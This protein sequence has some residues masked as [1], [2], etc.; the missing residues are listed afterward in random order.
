MLAESPADRFASYAALAAALEPFAAG[1][2]LAALAR[3]APPPTAPLA[4]PP[5]L[6]AALDLLVWD[7]AGRRH[8]SLAEPG[9]LP[10]REGSPFQIEVR[11]N[12]PAYLY[13]VW[14]DTHGRPL[15]LYPWR[16]GTWDLAEAEA[17]RAQLLLPQPD[18][19]RGYQPWALN[20][21][22]GVETVVLVA[23]EGGP[24]ADLPGLFT[25]GLAARPLRPALEGLPQ[26]ERGYWFTSRAEEHAP[27]TRG[28]NLSPDFHDPIF[29]I[30]SF[31]REQLG[32]R[33]PLLRAVS[34]ANLGRE[35]GPS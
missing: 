13:L 18:P 33:V 22:A 16:P 7:R 28:L 26:R 27:G 3:S 24:R 29:Q 17:P 5:P 32:A 35:G 34:F 10:L 8:R 25:A 1:S 15:P 14:L 21:E 6:H 30:H 11:L 23:Q 9:V 2:E 19:M 4:A 12:R 20:G 31:L